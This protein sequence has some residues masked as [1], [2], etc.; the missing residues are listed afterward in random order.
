MDHNPKGM[1]QTIP[2]PYASQD[3]YLEQERNI[4]S[5]AKM[6][7]LYLTSVYTK[8]TNQVRYS[9]RVTCRPRF[10]MNPV[11]DSSFILESMRGYLI[12][13]LTSIKN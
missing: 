4:Q 13:R 2:L 5:A 6:Q 12:R 9:V 8:A 11:V 1:S 3:P 7:Y 10:D